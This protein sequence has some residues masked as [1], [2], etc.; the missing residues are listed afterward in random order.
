[1]EGCAPLFAVLSRLARL[2]AR[3]AL[4]NLSIIDINAVK[5]GFDAAVVC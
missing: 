4:A 3:L 5:V 2:A 1:M